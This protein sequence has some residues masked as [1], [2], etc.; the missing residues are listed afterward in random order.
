M[1]IK[2]DSVFDGDAVFPKIW[3]NIASSFPLYYRE[4]A[5]LLGPTAKAALNP[6]P[7]KR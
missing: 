5:I 2:V 4:T 3:Q 1:I 6:K 7:F